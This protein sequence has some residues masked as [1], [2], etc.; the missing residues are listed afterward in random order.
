MENK[1]TEMNANCWKRNVTTG[2][3]VNLYPTLC[4]IVFLLQ[5][6]IFRKQKFNKH[7]QAKTT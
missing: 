5:S 1:E 6:L 4:D 7:K 2:D 3:D